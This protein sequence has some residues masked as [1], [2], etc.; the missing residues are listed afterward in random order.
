MGNTTQ[1]RERRQA[2]RLRDLFVRDPEQFDWVWNR[3]LTGWANEIVVRGRSLRAHESPDKDSDVLAILNKA[4]RLLAA[5]GDAAERRVG[6]G[7]RQLLGHECCKAIAA[8]TDSRLY[9]LT[10]DSVY[11]VMEACG[12]QPKRSAR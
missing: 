3:Y 11:R 5:V 8:A 1:R 9:L 6:H 10:H 12:R 2:E 7:T 4:E